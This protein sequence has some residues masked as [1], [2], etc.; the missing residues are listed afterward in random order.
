M[1]LLKKDRSA[2][3]QA[4][5]LKST[6]LEDIYTKKKNCVQKHVTL[7]EGL[8]K[9]LQYIIEEDYETALEWLKNAYDVIADRANYYSYFEEDNGADF[10]NVFEWICL[11][12]SYCYSKLDDFANAYYYIDQVY[13]SSDCTCFLQWIDVIIDGKRPDALELVLSFL[14][15]DWDVMNK[16]SDEDKQKVVN[17]LSNRLG[18]LY[19]E[20][21]LL[22]E[23]RDYFSSFLS[24]PT[25]GEYAREGLE[26]LD[27]LVASED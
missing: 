5:S 7:Q 6:V 15:E 26:Y 8:D 16:W 3:K 20:Y 18:Y 25:S 13:N 4:G 12:L 1:K 22:D 19:I 11:R 2:E 17:Y 14:E 24:S 21:H 9:A 10:N 23:A 27:S